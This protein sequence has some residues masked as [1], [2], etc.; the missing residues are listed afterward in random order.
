[1][2]DPPAEPSIEEILA[3]IRRIIAEESLTAAPAAGP[4]ASGPAGDEDE[5][6]LLRTV[7]DG[8]AA[9]WGHGASLAEEALVLED[10]EPAPE[11][12]PGAIVRGLLMADLNT[13]APA[14]A[15]LGGEPPAATTPAPETPA[16]ET[17]VPEPPAAEPLV[18]DTAAA[19]A[20]QAF[21]ALERR[22]QLPA[23]GRTLEDVVREMLRPILKDWLD[24]HLPA[25]V[26]AQV[27][28]EI[29]RI[30]R[31]RR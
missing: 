28:E 22:L 26:Q 16:P 7:L 30:A 10:I 20:A 12:A 29:E 9:P 21:G 3:S 15:E 31:Q 23:A 24:Q 18:G 1:M 11:A 17:P 6:L 8:D 19:A 4:Q 5:P 27:A 2:S 25:I 14:P 13:E